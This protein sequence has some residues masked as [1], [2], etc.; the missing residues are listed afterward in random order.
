MFGLQSSQSFCDV[1]GSVE[2]GNSDGDARA[3]RDGHGVRLPGG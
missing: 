1:V 3:A 2:D